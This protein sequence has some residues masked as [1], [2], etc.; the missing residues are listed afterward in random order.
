MPSAMPIS[1]RY[2]PAETASSAP[3]SGLAAQVYCSVWLRYCMDRGSS[4]QVHSQIRMI[5]AVTHVQYS[6]D[7]LTLCCRRRVCDLAKSG[8]STYRVPLFRCRHPAVFQMGI[9][10][11]WGTLH[12]SRYRLRPSLVAPSGHFLSAWRHHASFVPGDEYK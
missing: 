8:R 12:R 7:A 9:R 5:F 1:H 2:T 4:L 11:W 6:S 3:I 10:L